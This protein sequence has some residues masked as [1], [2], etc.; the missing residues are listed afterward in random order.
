M[1]EH[2]A[3]DGQSKLVRTCSYPLTGL[4]CVTRVYT[5]LAVLDLTPAGF[6]VRDLCDGMTAE[7]LGILSGVATRR[8]P[9]Q[10][11]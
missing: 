10:N 3:K 6:T 11:P 7:A 5:D 9:H 1:M 8:A 2:L 4:G